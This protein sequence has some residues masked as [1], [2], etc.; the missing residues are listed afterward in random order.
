MSS[1]DEL[2][3]RAAERAVDF[4][5][6]GMIVGL[7]T[8]STA[9]FAI[10]RIGEKIRSGDLQRIVGIPSSERTVN[11]ARK[12]NITLTDLE[13]HPAIDLTIDVCYTTLLADFDSL[14]ND[15]KLQG[16]KEFSRGRRNLNQAE[17]V[18]IRE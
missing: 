6:S 2:K 9:N 12:L 7:G 10:E 15:H 13:T 16:G 17:V 4:I 14:L 18:K 11:L 3:K 1:Q 8:G 5:E